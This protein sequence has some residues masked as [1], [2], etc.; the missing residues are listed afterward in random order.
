MQLTIDAC[1]TVVAPHFSI[2]SQSVNLPSLMSGQA[3]YTHR[4]SKDKLSGG[5][6]LGWRHTESRSSEEIGKCLFSNSLQGIR[7]CLQINVVGALVPNRGACNWLAD[8]FGLP[9]CFESI[10]QFNPK[11]TSSIADFALYLDF[12][13]CVPGLWFRAWTP[14]VH[15]RW[16]LNVRESNIKI[17][18]CIAASIV[19]PRSDGYS[20]GY[21]TNDRLSSESLVDNALSFFRKKKT[22]NL[23]EGF[24]FE[25][26]KVCRWYACGNQCGWENCEEYNDFTKRGFADVRFGLGYNVFQ[27]D[28]YHFGL[29]MMAAAPTGNRPNSIFLF[30]PMVGNGHH[31]EVGALLTS[32]IT[33]WRSEDE[34]KQLSIYCDAHIT[35]LFKTRQKRC[36]DLCGKPMSRYM[37][38]AGMTTNV[39]SNLFG[40]DTQTVG[41]VG[42]TGATGLAPSHQFNNKYAP[43]GNLTC[44]EVDVSVGVQAD[45]AAMLKY[46]YGGLSIDLGYNFWGR[47]CEKI[48][49]NDSC[50]L[51][52]IAQELWVLKGDI[53]TYGFLAASPISV[54]LSASNSKATIFSGTDI[55]YRIN[56]GTGGA[57]TSNNITADNAKFA[58]NSPDKSA[59]PYTNLEGVNPVQNLISTSVNPILLTLQDIDIKGA[60]TKGR[61]HSVFGSMSYAWLDYGNWIPTLTVGSQGE[62]ASNGNNKR[63]GAQEC[64]SSCHDSRCCCN[65][66][67]RCAISQWSV[68]VQGGVAFN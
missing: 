59:R 15:T 57:N 20:E 33:F 47:S 34:E 26:L 25:P 30:E 28:T 23:G 14:L 21:F 16:N 32:H 13:A 42:G 8:Y 35:H 17:L 53:R 50:S 38:A 10:M 36:F 49:F 44:S 29:G 11:I 46:T 4:F 9:S 64:S 7:N 19:N 67:T 48:R 24:S 41:G 43:I 1:S 6:S 51:P 58:Q 39:S 12:N 61:S 31:W 5:F 65:K 63:R 3:E 40:A 54:A 22:P 2:R 18:N 37:L 27:N 56:T 68:F 55:P 45:V 66:G 60:C 62:F 52:R